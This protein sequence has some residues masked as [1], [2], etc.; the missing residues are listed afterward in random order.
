MQFDF[1]LAGANLPQFLAGA[2]TTMLVVLPVLLL[3]MIL[4]LPLALAR[5]S[6]KPWL[7]WPAAAYVAFF[8]GAPGLILL[9]FVYYGIAQIAAVRAGPL[10]LLFSSAYNCAVIAYTLN[11]TSYVT[12]ILRG[13]LGSVPAGLVEAAAALGLKPRQ[14][15]LY[16]RIPVAL[17][18]GLKAYQNE[19]LIFIKGTAALSAITVVDLTAAANKVFYLT[20]DPFTPLLTAAAIY[21]AMINLMRIGFAG[22]EARL[23]AHLIVEAASRRPAR[24]NSAALAGRRLN[25][26]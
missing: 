19:V 17:R 20:Y 5:L 6:P 26:R 1:A 9:Y 10:W 14:I 22:L 15:L 3:G 21:W 18:L 4:S 23:N 12:E 2:G 8:R 7:A 24:G 25:R 13:A 16:I 11:H